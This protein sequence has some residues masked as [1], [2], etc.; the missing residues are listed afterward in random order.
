MDTSTPC[1]EIARLLRS[2]ESITLPHKKD[3]GVMKYLEAA[4]APVFCNII[5]NLPKIGC[6]NCNFARALPYNIYLDA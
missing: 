6:V 2:H 5:I 1:I 4:S 3:I